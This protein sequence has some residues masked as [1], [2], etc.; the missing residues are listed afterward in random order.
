MS[1]KVL[2][3]CLNKNINLERSGSE[4]GVSVYVCAFGNNQYEPVEQ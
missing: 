4:D 2:S 3:L 1:I